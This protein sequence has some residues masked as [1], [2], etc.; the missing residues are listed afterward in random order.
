LK[1]ALGFVS[2]A[3]NS[4]THDELKAYSGFDTKL[5]KAELPSTTSIQHMWWC[6]WGQ[7]NIP[8]Y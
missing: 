8:L 6:Q 4:L 3:C 2:V 1:Q 5:A 7:L